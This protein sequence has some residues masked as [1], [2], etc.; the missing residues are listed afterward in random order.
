[1][2]HIRKTENTNIIY[3]GSTTIFTVTDKLVGPYSYTVT[4][5]LGTI[6][7][8]LSNTVTQSIPQSNTSMDRY[9][10]SYASDSVNSIVV[11]SNPQEVILL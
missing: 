1:M 5:T 2:F 9:C 10:E 8:D 3:Q 4:A 6:S 11:L 7:S